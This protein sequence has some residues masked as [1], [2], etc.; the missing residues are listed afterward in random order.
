MT[1][2]GIGGGQSSRRNLLKTLAVA[3]AAAALRT[4]PGGRGRGGLGPWT[5]EQSLEQMDKFDIAVAMMSMTQMGDILYDGTAKGA[6]AV[7]T[8]ND[9]GAKIMAEHPKRFGLFTGVPLPDIDGVMKEIEYGLDKL[10]AD[11][12]GIYT[13]DNHNR[14]P[15]DPYYE[16]MWQELNRRNAIVYMH[17]LAPQ[18][19]RDL[20]DSVP[21]AMNEFDFDITRACTSI[22]ANGVL[23]RY[24]NL[25]II[26]PHSGGTMPMIAGRIKDRY[27][28]D[29]KRD[30]YIPNGVI[31][32]LQ[33]FYIDIAHASFPYPMAA[34]LKFAQPDHVLFGTDFS[35]EPIES[36]V[37][38]LPKLGLSAQVMR[39]IERE[40]AERLFPRFKV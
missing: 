10:K 34:M 27:P 2:Y 26:I 28:H 20:N 22:L 36:T 7:R 15:G 39:A 25:K 31:P 1:D 8:G 5:P 14:W 32:E 4:G 6:A 17:P 38:E 24:P 16:P 29:P 18:C 11:G 19:C 12:I 9:Y 35:P 21:N 23:H 30:E 40:N 37:N 13:N 33:K 3:G